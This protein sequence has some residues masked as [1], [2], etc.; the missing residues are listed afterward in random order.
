MDTDRRKMHIAIEPHWGEG[1]M[2]PA[3]I[4]DTGWS[5]MGAVGATQQPTRNQRS[6][7]SRATTEVMA[8]F[9]AVTSAL[10][11]AAPAAAEPLLVDTTVVPL[12]SNPN[13]V[14]VDMGRG[15]AYVSIPAMDE[16]L[17]I[18][19]ATGEIQDRP[20]LPAPAGLELSADGKYLYVALNYST[21]IARVD[22]SD[23]SST[24]VVLAELGNNRTWDV[25]EISPGVVL[26]SANSG[27]GGFAWIVRY[28]FNT[29]VEDR[30]ASERIIRAGPRFAMDGGD[31]VYI[32]EGFSPNSLY[33]LDLATPML[34]IV[35]EDAHSTVSG[36]QSL[37]VSV[38]GSFIVVESG[39]K[40]D[41]STIA[42]IGNF[43]RGKPLF[44]DDGSVLYSYYSLEGSPLVSVS[45]AGTTQLIEQWQPDC[46]TAGVPYSHGVFTKGAGSPL[47]L[48]TTE[49]SL[50][51]IHTDTIRP[52]PP[53]PP[54]PPPSVPDGGLFF[55]D[56]GSIHESS[57]EA[58][59]SA[60]IT[61]GCNPPYQT[62]YC[63]NS[64]VTREQMAAF[65]VRALGL[66]D[67]GGGNSFVDDDGS[68]F[69][70]DIAKLA[71][72]GVTKGCNPPDNDLFCP[73]SAVTRGQMAAFLV[74][75]M[76]YADTGG[77]DSFVDDDGSVFENDIAKL[78]A[79]GVT[80]GC[81]P[82]ANDRYCPDDPV[83]RAQMATFLTRA[84]DLP[85]R[86]VPPRLETISG[87]DLAVIALADMVGCSGADG[88]MCN[89][90]GSANG[91]FYLMSGWF[92]DGWSSLPAAEK[93]EFQSSKVRLEATFDGLPIDLLEWPFE[94]IDDTAF[95]T[96]SFQF[97]GWLEGNHVLEV[98]FI[99]EFEDY[100]WII[101]DDLSTFGSGY[102]QAT[103]AVAAASVDPPDRSTS[104]AVERFV[105]R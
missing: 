80:K 91:Q 42:P 62:G 75:A 25:I 89:I 40:I 71:A 99:D 21:G 95:K 88:E 68:I 57:I 78:A 34:D 28:D 104:S 19:L 26:V 54:P 102:P 27:S 69:E 53:P 93:T 43:E 37:T 92:V 39:Q 98:S 82:P 8:L 73:N 86:T 5:D 6:R 24:Q 76:G 41:A 47:L 50:C 79:A 65:L 33:Q 14:V 9:L 3:S 22:L 84:L 74:R 77:G 64:A 61:K 67:T 20:V 29:G 7:L 59:A 81:N 1:R 58:I 17:S 105:G 49:D 48:T 101:R 11:L 55:D 32:G 85:V 70:N 60:G 44:S 56:D 16:I 51:M 66:T 45:N 13:D 38:D 52:V 100:L 4:S 72:A 36:T 94:V 23:W 2:N 63:P 10:V 87:T 83:T 103:P 97:P 96:Y 30:V 31:H 46:G 35:A 12:S 15:L 90:S 18:N